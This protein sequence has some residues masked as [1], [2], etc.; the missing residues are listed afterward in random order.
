M[1]TLLAALSALLA[2][3]LAWPVPTRLAAASWP[4]RNPRR[5]ITLWQVIG[6]SGGICAV[7][8]L[9]LLGLDPLGPRWTLLNLAALAGA[10]ILLSWL[11][12]VLATNTIRIERH[13][14][15]QRDAVDLLA[16]TDLNGVR[17]LDH[18][19]PAAYCLPGPRPRIVVTHGA[20]ASLGPEE[21]AAVLA[22]ER[23]HAVG[24]HELIIQ[25][26]VAWESALPFLPPARRA[27]AAVAELVEM[28]ADDHA[29]RETSPRALARALAQVGSD[30]LPSAD[31][32][33][34]P[35]SVLPRVRRLVQ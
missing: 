12:G 23:A 27:T 4:S 18:P 1:V 8:S 17:V 30:R 15:K 32:S 20:I 9:L 25:P 5:A 7:G 16:W 29:A 19:E 2:V 35:A 24:R 28:L 31:G 13:L 22:H 14:R 26:F 10:A 6:L 11:L 33:A 3:L 34:A 21:L